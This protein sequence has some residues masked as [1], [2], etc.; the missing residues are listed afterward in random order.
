M[1]DAAIDCA[2]IRER[3]RES[4]SHNERER[5]RDWEIKEQSIGKLL[6]KY[7]FISYLS[8][9]NRNTVSVSPS[10]GRGSAAFENN[11]ICHLFLYF[12]PSHRVFI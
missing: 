6:L 7:T 3:G 1:A 12:Q 9:H 4:D 5:E 11:K 2:I 10:I 8:F